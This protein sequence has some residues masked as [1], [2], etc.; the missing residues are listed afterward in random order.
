M[1]P[2]ADQAGARL[3][4]LLGGSVLHPEGGSY[5]LAVFASPTL[6]SALFVSASF[7][8]WLY[9]ILVDAQVSVPYLY[10]PPAILCAGM[11]VLSFLCAGICVFPILCSRQH[12]RHVVCI[13]PVICIRQYSPSMCATARAFYTI[14]MLAVPI[15]MMYSMSFNVGLIHYRLRLL[16]F[17]RASIYPLIFACQCTCAFY[18][19]VYMGILS[20]VSAVV[21]APV[22]KGILYHHRLYAHP[23]RSTA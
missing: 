8:V 19:I 11:C 23:V 22:C 7:S 9:S 17:V 1:P 21:S 13:H 6:V 12:S 16:S 18:V 14:G 20:F 10:V 3:N 2:C 5:A 4:A 15:M